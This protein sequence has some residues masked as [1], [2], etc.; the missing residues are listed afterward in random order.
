[1]MHSTFICHTYPWLL[2]LWI[3]SCHRFS[4]CLPP[5]L[6]CERKETVL[7]LKYRCDEEH[8][9]IKLNIE[10]LKEVGAWLNIEE[11]DDQE[12]YERR[13]Q[14]AYDEQWNK[15]DYNIYNRETRHIDPNPKCKRMDGRKGYIQRE[16]EDPVFDIMDYLAVAPAA[17]AGVDDDEAEEWIRKIL[18]KKPDVADAFIATKY[19]DLTIRAY[20][21]KIAKPGDDVEKLE[22]NLSKKLTRA[23]KVLAAAYLDRRF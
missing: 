15:P 8:G 16:L 3:V 18:C 1:M 17:D 13:I 6:G 11:C 21:E 22:S 10:E 14:E 2:N 7:Y 4:L 19:G 5:I 9:A 20:A 23:T 12:E